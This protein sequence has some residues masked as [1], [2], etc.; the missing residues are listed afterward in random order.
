M[1]IF[2]V[3][4][5]YMIYKYTEMQ[6]AF[7][8][9]GLFCWVRWVSTTNAAVVEVHTW[10]T[11]TLWNAVCEFFFSVEY[12]PPTS[13]SLRCHTWYTNTLWNAVYLSFGG[14]P[15]WFVRWTNPWPT[16]QWLSRY[17]R[18]TC[19][20]H[21]VIESWYM[22]RNMIYMYAPKC[23]WVVI[24]DIHVCWAYMIY[25]YAPK[26]NEMYVVILEMISN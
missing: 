20:L 18:Y 3:S 2:L 11:C 15:V 21:N 26:C 23:D 13:Q 25:M 9:G 8:G 4:E 17:T 12:S 16:Q 24:H 14:G 7:W 6:Y 19:T 5:S 10:H 22:C 1:P